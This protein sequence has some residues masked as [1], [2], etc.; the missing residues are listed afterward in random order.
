M[1]N[2]KLLNASGMNCSLSNIFGKNTTKFILAIEVAD[3]TNYLDQ[4]K[5]FVASSNTHSRCSVKPSAV[6]PKLT[7]FEI[8]D[9]S[10]IDYLIIEECD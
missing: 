6:T 7:A 5:Q 2:I 8:S 10:N 3:K 9:S 1:K 4:V